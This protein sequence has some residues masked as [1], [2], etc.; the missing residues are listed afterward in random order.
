PLNTEHIK[1]MSRGFAMIQFSKGNRP[2]IKSGYTLDDNA[3]AL[4]ALS[5]MYAERKDVSCETY[6]ETYLN[7][8]CHC[9]QTDGSFLNYVHKDI[10]FTSQNEE[11]GLEDSNGRAIMA[12]GYFIS[13][14]G[15]FPDAWTLDAIR[16]IKQTFPMITRL[17]SPRSMAFVIKGL[18]SYWRKY[19]SPEICSL[20]K[21]LADKL[22]NYYR[23]NNENKWSWFE[24]YL[25]YDNS[26]LPESLLYAFMA[27][28]DTIYKET[29]K[30]SFDF[31]LEKTFTGE[32][33]KVVS[34]QGWLQKEREGQKFG[35]Q[36]IDV[37][38]TVI[39]LHTFYTV[40]KDEAYLAKQKTA[41]NWFLG[42]NHLHQIIYNPATG[43]CYDG[44]EENNI[45]LNQG[46][47]SA[48]CYLMARLTMD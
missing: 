42:N 23:Q 31:L 46:A 37:A 48:V 35:E 45:N 7:F 26:V 13:H 36:P 14:A 3:R 20:I 18:Y 40:F 21:L 16:M 6:I 24:A 29:A 15:K 2:D 28:G 10:L 33:I 47:E 8:I 38:G 19:P 25:T 22:I 1:R 17:Q 34:N 12:L 30:E 39:A 9:L 44:L 27:T 43:G 41:F 32:Q 11:T 5:Q 4:I